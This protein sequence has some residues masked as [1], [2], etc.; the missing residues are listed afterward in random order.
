MLISKKSEFGRLY[1]NMRTIPSLI[2]LI[3]VFSS[4]SSRAEFVRGDKVCTTSIKSPFRTTCR[5]PSDAGELDRL[6]AA[7]VKSK[8]FEKCGFSWARGWESERDRLLKLIRGER[9]SLA[10]F[11]QEV[12]WARTDISK[13]HIL[14]SDK[15]REAYSTISLWEPIIRESRKNIAE[16]EWCVSCALKKPKSAAECL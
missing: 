4:Y 13:S 14:P 12:Y 3:L 11:E 1:K 9:D 8:N 16:L 2:F 7:E 15:I 5:D 10:Y 6:R